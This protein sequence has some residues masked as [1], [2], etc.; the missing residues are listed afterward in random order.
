[1]LATVFQYLRTK[2]F[3]HIRNYIRQDGIQ[4]QGMLRPLYLF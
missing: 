3:T 2:N 1:M 4:R